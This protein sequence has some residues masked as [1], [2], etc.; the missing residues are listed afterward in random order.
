[1][2]RSEFA[3][4]MGSECD[5]CTCIALTRFQNFTCMLQLGNYCSAEEKF[6]FAMPPYSSVLSHSCQDRTSSDWHPNCI[7]LMSLGEQSMCGKTRKLD[8]LRM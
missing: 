5:F 3:C 1:M 7:L 6:S 8:F 4:T 2:T